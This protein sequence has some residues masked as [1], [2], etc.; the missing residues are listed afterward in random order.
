[1]KRNPHIQED[2][3]IFIENNM[4]LAQSVA[5]KFIPTTRTKG[6]D[7]DD[8]FSMAYLGLVKAYIQFNPTKFEKD[9]KFSTYAVPKIKSEISNNLRDNYNPM[10]ITREM[11]S[12]ATKI[13]KAGYTR[14]DNPI[15]I[16]KELNMPLSEVKEVMGIIDDKYIV[17]SLDREIDT[18]DSSET[19]V[20]SVPSTIANEVESNIIVGDFLR[21]LSENLN[22]VYELRIE[23]GLSQRETGEVLGLN[24]KAISRLEKKM[25]DL[26]RDYFY[27]SVI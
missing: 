18:D 21:S 20:D 12:V 11:R 25:Y 1:M 10:G 17:Q 5:W 2:P 22:R 4:K 24:Q 16:S 13:R 15:E 23:H 9:I 6:I 26:G 14:E 8:I 7:D 19:I 27:E 3:N